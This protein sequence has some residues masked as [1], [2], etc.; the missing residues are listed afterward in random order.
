MNVKKLI[1]VVVSIIVGSAFAEDWASPSRVTMNMFPNGYTELYEGRLKLYGEE[2]NDGKLADG[3]YYAMVFWQ[4]PY[5]GFW[6]RTVI[7]WSWL[8]IQLKRWNERQDINI[9]LGYATTD[10]E[11]VRIFDRIAYHKDAQL[12]AYI[13][14]TIKDNCIVRIY[15]DDEDWK[16]YGE[17]IGWW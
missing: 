8:S 9:D 16:R 6:G 2:V 5:A 13:K 7:G 17:S 1:F 4:A 10:S 3:E 15:T 14:V 12:L 11:W